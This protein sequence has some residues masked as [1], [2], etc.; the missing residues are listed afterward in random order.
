MR[1]EI[2]IFSGLFFVFISLSVLG[3]TAQTSSAMRPRLSFLI[4][5]GREGLIKRFGPDYLKIYGR[6]EKTAAAESFLLAIAEKPLNKEQISV[7]SHLSLEQIEEIASLYLSLNLITPKNESWATTVPV[8][9]DRQMEAL[10]KN[11]SPLAEKIAMNVSRSIPQIKNAYD[12]HHSANNPDWEKVSHLFIDF[13]LMDSNFL[14]LLE[15][16][17]A[18]KGFRRQYTEKQNILPA[19]YLELG[20]NF[21]NFGCNSYFYENKEKTRGIIVYVLHATLFSRTNILVNQYDDNP[22]FLSALFKLPTQ[23]SSGFLQFSENEKEILDA[24]GWKVKEKFLVPVLDNDLLKH[25]QPLLKKAAW[26]AA[27]TVSENFDLIISTF[28][29]SPYARFLDG[30]GDYIQYCYHALMYL[31]IANLIQKRFLPSVPTPIHE[32]FAN[33]IVYQSTR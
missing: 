6:S 27:K 14:S 25:L 30:A 32:Y 2:L 21:T 13:F 29:D 1:K 28:Q 5:G 10:V 19:F 31:T 24:L 8:I 3:W 7:Q 22:D 16:F 26:S 12:K 15:K 11:L 18:Q 9:T 17:E 4:V 23:A 33:Y 20:N